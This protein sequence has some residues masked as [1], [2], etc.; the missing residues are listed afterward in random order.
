MPRT[1][2]SSTELHKGFQWHIAEP[3]KLLLPAALWSVPR[4]TR[5]HQGHTQQTASRIDLNLKS[6]K[7]CMWQSVAHHGFGVDPDACSESCTQPILLFT[8]FFFPSS[9]SVHYCNGIREL[10]FCLDCV[11]QIELILHER[12]RELFHDVFSRELGSR[13]QFYGWPN[14][15]RFLVK[16]IFLF[17]PFLCTD[18]RNSGRFSS[19]HR[20]RVQV[21]KHTFLPRDRKPCSKGHKT[22]IFHHSRRDRHTQLDTPQISS[23][24]LSFIGSSPSFSGKRSGRP[25][26]YHPFM[27]LSGRQA[28]PCGQC[29]II[30]SL[31]P[32][33]WTLGVCPSSKVK[34]VCVA[35][36]TVLSRQV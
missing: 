10:R 11:V 29:N 3:P 27:S 4:P 25:P 33:R 23:K 36:L 22:P 13:T 8:F 35:F 1:T 21:P 17:L 16:E 18:W 9:N 12:H 6:L 31:F 26:R 19:D 28:H 14:S 7:F 30:F 20:T 2:T 34:E 15:S 5:A 24:S 32:R